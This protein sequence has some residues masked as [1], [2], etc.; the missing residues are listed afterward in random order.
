MTDAYGLLAPV[1]D[2][3]DAMNRALFWNPDIDVPSLFATL[4]KQLVA[5]TAEMAAL[6]PTLRDPELDDEPTIQER[7]EPSTE[8]SS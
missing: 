4:P 8:G 7:A 5:L 1:A 2:T 3:L 6:I